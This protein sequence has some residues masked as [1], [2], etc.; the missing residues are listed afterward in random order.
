M[1]IS[2]NKVS[3]KIN[4]LKGTRFFPYEGLQESLE[5]NVEEIKKI[6]DNIELIKDFNKDLFEAKNTVLQA[7]LPILIDKAMSDLPSRTEFLKNI[8]TSCGGICGLVAALEIVSVIAAPVALV[9]IV[10]GA[11]LATTAQFVSLDDSSDITGKDLSAITGYEVE[12]NNTAYI[13]QKSILNYL[14]ENVNEN[15]DAIFKINDKE[16]KLRDLIN[17]PLQKGLAWDNSVTLAQRIYR[18][19][20]VTHQ[21]AREQ[22]LDLYFIQ[23]TIKFRNEYT[24]IWSKFEHGHCYQPCAAPNP[25]GTQRERKFKISDIGQDVEIFNNSEV[26][27]FNGCNNYCSRGNTVDENDKNK[28]VGSYLNAIK[29]FTN[30]FKCTYI[31]PWSVGESYILSQKYFIVLGKPKLRDD[32]NNPHYTLPDNDFLNWLFIDDGVGNIINP[33]G[34]AF[35]Y[36]ILRSKS[37]LGTDCDIFLHAQQIADETCKNDYSGKNKYTDNIICSSSDF[38]YGPK[39]SAQLNQ[40]Y[41]VYTGDLT[42]S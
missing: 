35:R 20:F 14:K 30:D 19:I 16:F 29:Q 40:Q 9:F 15:R 3:K 41:H 38:R 12:Y 1:S 4:K 11:I 34:V 27:H 7:A 17:S 37:N 10:A 39:E 24:R 42:L 8:L 26:V 36:D 31:Y 18:N 28:K 22:V 5:L 32:Q 6:Q 13:A 23:D 25:P 33:N 21:L 2:E